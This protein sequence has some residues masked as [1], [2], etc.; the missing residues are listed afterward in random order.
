MKRV[1]AVRP[2]QARSILTY[3]VVAASGFLLAYLLV[4]LV[5]FPNREDVP[6]D[7]AVPGVVG[8][9]QTDAQR[10]LVSA[11]LA[12]SL[13]EERFSDDAPRSTVL[14]Q[15]PAAGEAVARGTTVTLDVSAGQQRASIPA[16]VGQ[17]RDAATRVLNNHGLHVG[18]VTEEP[19]ESPRGLVLASRPDGGQVVPMGTRIDLV[20][21][22]G[23]P[24]LSMPDLIGRDEVSA[25]ALVRQLGLAMGEIVRDE[26]SIMP[27]GTVIG[28]SPV[29]GGQ[30]SPGGTVNLRVSARP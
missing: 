8:L 20:V 15:R 26:T 27:F 16:I 29:A 2:D 3:V 1:R 5:V 18:E 25:T 14:A 10:R 17:S 7:V 23:P 28:Q 22:A 6:A 30:V 11:G 9:T 21:S 24:Q 4:L 12:A 19:S 13:G